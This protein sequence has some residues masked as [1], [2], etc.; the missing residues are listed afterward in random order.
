[1]ID[2]DSYQSLY[3]RQKTRVSATVPVSVH[4]PPPS[5]GL[6][7]PVV[8][9]HI[10]YFKSLPAV[11]AW[12]LYGHVWPVLPPAERVDQNRLS[13]VFWAWDNRGLESFRKGVVEGKEE[14]VASKTIRQKNS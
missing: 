14:G 12:P 6:Y 3:T 7:T 9:K 1:M 11:T 13:R 10:N 4:W 2:A 5:F 8:R